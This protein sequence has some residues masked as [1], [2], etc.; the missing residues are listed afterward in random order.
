MKKKLSNAPHSSMFIIV[1]F[2]MVIMTGCSG[3]EQHEE[4]QYK[5]TI[6]GMYGADETYND[7]GVMNSDR[8]IVYFCDPHTGFRAPICTKINCTHE[9]RNPTNFTPDCDAYFS[10]AINCTA[11]IDDILYYVS[12]PDDKGIF[13]KE[14]CRA[15]KNGINRKVIA[16]FDNVE[17]PTFM[18]YEQ[19]YLIYAYQNQDDPSGIPLD[20]YKIG[21]ILVDLKTGEAKQIE[22]GEFLYAQIV[23]CSVSDNYLYYY[24]MYNDLDRAYDYDEL[25]DPERQEIMRRSVKMELW[26]YNLE[27]GTKSIVPAPDGYKFK[28]MGYNY[29]LYLSEN[30]DGYMLKSMGDGKEYYLADA[31]AGRESLIQFSEGVIFSYDN[32][33]S[34]WKCGTDKKEKIGTYPDDRINILCIT[35]HWVYGIR[36][37]DAESENVSCSKD[38]FMNG[39]FE[40]TVLPL[41]ETR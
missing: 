19:G 27:D 11:I 12:S 40:W 10:E 34:I 25:A 20:K 36:I 1:I 14:F 21:I 38:K 28:N 2:I 29:I 24:F 16:A 9:S 5:T 4:N 6:S 26:K 7:T 17:I 32:T 37:N 23:T 15:D 39:D 30:R 13:L 18:S 8:G 35:E 31:N 33:I 3:K 22:T 41:Y